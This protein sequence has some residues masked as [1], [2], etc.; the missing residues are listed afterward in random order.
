MMVM[1][2]ALAYGTDQVRMSKFLETCQI[3]ILG[4][5]FVDEGVAL[6]C[7]GV[8]QSIFVLQAAT[9]EAYKVVKWGLEIGVSDREL[10]QAVGEEAR[11]Q[12]KK[13]KVHL[14]IDTGMGRLGCRLE[15]ALPLAKAVQSQPG[16]ELEGIMTHFACADDPAQD[17]FTLQQAESFRQIIEQL[18]KEG[19]AL[20]WRHAANSSAAVRFHFPH[21]NMVRIGLAAYGLY[22]SKA[23]QSAVELRLALALTS[24]IVGINSCKRGE[25]VSYGRSYCVER[26]MQRIAV[27]PI[28]YF[29]GLHG[30]YSGKGAV[31]IHGQKAPMIGKICM[32]FMM[33]DITDIPAA[34]VGDPVLVFGEDE[35]GS[36]LSPEELA[37]QGDSI[38][39]ELITC[40]GPRIER[41]FIH[42]ESRSTH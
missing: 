33:V 37:A 34:A 36:Y 24:R 30:S 19:I 32:D 26:S 1:V 10:I 15:E 11:K 12:G 28:G 7:A 6:K 8:S 42:E 38:I 25:T 5:S 23:V 14:H 39:H 22:S 35:H 17:S 27:L 18:E 16:L 41:I 29:D 2:K 13:I 4:V 20:R 31:V 21:C 40:L 9:Y 3:D